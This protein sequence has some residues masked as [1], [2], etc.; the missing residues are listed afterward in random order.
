VARIRKELEGFTMPEGPEIAKHGER[1]KREMWSQN[2]GPPP[3][4]VN[5]IH[6]GNKFLDVKVEDIRSCLDQPLLE[7]TYKGKELYIIFQDS[8]ILNGQHGIKAVRGHLGMKGNWFTKRAEELAFM[9]MNDYK[10]IH[11]RLDFCYTVGSIQTEISIFYQNERFGNFDIL[12]N[13]S[14][15]DRALDNLAPGFVGAYQISLQEWCHRWA[16]VGATRYLRDILM[17][18]RILCSGVGNYIAIEFLYE[19]KCHPAVR[20]NYFTENDVVN[21]YHI[22]KF[23][24]IG[25]FDGSLE[26]RIY[27]KKVDPCGKSVV[28]EKMFSRPMYW[29]PEVQRFGFP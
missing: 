10:N 9:T 24:M 1:L 4:L 7:I 26:K 11:F 18:Q 8:Q 2:G 22:L 19:I 28:Y 29:V 15:F 5:F 25:F 17:D 3:R 14:A 13:K 6:I 23:L 20:V 16:T 21:M 12:P 27:K